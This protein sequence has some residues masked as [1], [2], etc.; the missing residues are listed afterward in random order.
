MFGVVFSSEKMYMKAIHLLW[1][2]S[3]HFIGQSQMKGHRLQLPT[4]ACLEET[5]IVH[6]QLK[7]NTCRR[8]KLTKTSQNVHILSNCFG[9]DAFKASA[10]LFDSSRV[11][12]DAPEALLWSAR[13]ESIL[14][15]MYDFGM[16]VLMK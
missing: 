13:V 5:F 15:C 12:S 6:E 9:W 8:P 7:E 2:D 10:C 14:N 1:N 3:K 16:E 4:S 11:H